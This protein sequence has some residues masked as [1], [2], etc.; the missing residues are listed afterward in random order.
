MSK[1]RGKPW[2]SLGFLASCYQSPDYWALEEQ[3]FDFSKK[4]ALALNKVPRPSK[5]S[6]NYVRSNRA[7]LNMAM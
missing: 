4:E 3:S 1:N 7:I 6:G 2:A 5:G